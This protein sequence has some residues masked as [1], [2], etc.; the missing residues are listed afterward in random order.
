MFLSEVSVRLHLA[1]HYKVVT[2]QQLL[3]RAVLFQSLVGTA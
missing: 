2:L 3:F 1:D